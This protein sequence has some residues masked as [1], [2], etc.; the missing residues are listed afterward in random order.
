MSTCKPYPPKTDRVPEDFSWYEPVPKNINPVS[1]YSDQKLLYLAMRNPEI[2]NLV[3][4]ILFYR[5]IK[6]RALKTR[7]SINQEINHVNK[8]LGEA[9]EKMK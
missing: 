6:R 2:S 4:K 9:Y 3:L 5:N 7:R 8:I 1:R